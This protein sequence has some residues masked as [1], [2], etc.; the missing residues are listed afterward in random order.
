MAVAVHAGAQAFKGLRRG[1]ARGHARW[2]KRTQ[3]RSSHAQRAKHQRGPSAPL[4]RR[5]V[6]RKI[7]APQVT[8]QHLQR[9]YRQARAQR[10]PQ[11]AA[12]QPQHQ[13]FEQHQRHAVAALQ[14]QHV[15]Q[16]KLLRPARHAQRQYRKH[17]KPAGKQRHQ[18][19][20]RQVDPVGA[21]HIAHALQRVARRLQHRACWPIRLRLQ[22]A[23][24]SITVHPGAQAHIYPAQLP[25]HAK[26]RLRRRHVHHHQRR[27][28]GR[29]RARH[30]QAPPLHAVLHANA[31]AH[32]CRQC[33]AGAGV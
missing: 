15:E 20:H 16:R 23:G 18:R 5:C 28:T 19:Q 4:Q 30:P 27:A 12:Q 26:S 29:H 10:Q 11:R 33:A 14:A 13:G 8:A 22:R 9:R 7:A 6:A 25:T 1:Q 17:Q 32:F 21:R 2:Q 3:Q 24:Q 31:L